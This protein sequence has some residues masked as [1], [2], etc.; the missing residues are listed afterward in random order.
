MYC[1]D[2]KYATEERGYIGF[3]SCSMILDSND[4]EMEYTSP[5]DVEINH[6]TAD[7][8]RAYTWDGESYASGNYVGEN[9]GC[10]HF[11]EG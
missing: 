10:I 5:R 8:S 11:K 2:C 6:Q 4:Y 7:L 1:K 3:Y 9:F